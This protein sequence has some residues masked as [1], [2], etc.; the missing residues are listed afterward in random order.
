MKSPQDHAADEASQAI[1]RAVDETVNAANKI[2]DD[3]ARAANKLADEATA[4][5]NKAADA[6]VAAHARVPAAE[7]YDVLCG[8]RR[9][10]GERSGDAPRGRGKARPLALSYYECPA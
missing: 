4:R 6:K 1:N 7:G 2:R 9:R 10:G 3:A 5:A 8:E